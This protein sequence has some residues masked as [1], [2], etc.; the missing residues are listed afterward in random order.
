MGITCGHCKRT[1]ES[2][3][4]VRQCSNGSFS[5]TLRLETINVSRSAQ[6]DLQISVTESA[7]FQKGR[8]LP[9]RTSLGHDLFVF[10]GPNVE[11]SV[12]E[13]ATAGGTCSCGW[14]KYAA[15]RTA[16]VLAWNRH[17]EES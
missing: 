16:L 2:V 15:N 8:E 1:H 7:T 6:P 12:Y 14:T 5:T 13:S 9:Y 3:Y 11:E 17:V 4:E 10:D